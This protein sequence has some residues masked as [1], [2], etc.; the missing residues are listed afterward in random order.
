MMVDGTVLMILIAVNLFRGYVTW[1]DVLVWSS[2]CT[3][4][5]VQTWKARRSC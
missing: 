3:R 5:D 1:S 4:S 2:V